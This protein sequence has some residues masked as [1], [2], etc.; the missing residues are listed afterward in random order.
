MTIDL[1][2]ARLDA[3]LTILPAI[4]GSPADPLIRELGQLVVEL[5][6]AEEALPEG[7]R[8]RRFR[9]ELR[10]RAISAQKAR[11]MAAQRP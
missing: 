6:A 9:D 1:S 4:Q 3:L 8:V 5:E 11:A 10:Q 7:E 2:P